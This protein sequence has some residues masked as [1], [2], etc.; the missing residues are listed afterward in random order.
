MSKIYE[1][2]IKDFSGGI[3]D[4][5]R[6]QISNGA[7]LIKHFDIFSDKTR[8]IPHR[9]TEADTNDGSTADGM[10]TYDVRHFTLGS[11]GKL[12][13][14]GKNGSGYPKVVSKADP[15]TGNWTLEATA[16]GNA[17]RVVGAFIEWQG[18]WWFWQGTNQLAKWT[19]GSTVTNSVLTVGSTITTVAQGIIGADNNL[20]MFYNGKVVRINSSGTATDDVLSALPSD[21]RIT[22]V[23]PYGSYIAI[24]IAFGTSATASP[25]GRSK[26]FL[27]DMV[28][29]SSVSDV[30]DW[31]EGALMCLG[32][33]EG[34][35]C[36]VSDKYLSSS[37]G[38]GTG[39]MVVRLWAGGIPQVMKEIVANQT[40]TLGRFLN[41]VV[42]KNNKMYWVA[43]VPF[44]LSTATESTF[45]LGIW[46]FGRKNVNSDFALSLDYIE[47]GID[48]SNYKIVS[49]GAAGD[50]WF[51]NH[52]NDG[53]ITKTDD[54]ANYTFTSIYESQIF[55]NNDSSE[56]K[57]LIGV[58]VFTHPLPAAGQ[59]VLKYKKDEDT[60]WT[61][62]FTYGTDNCIS[63]SAINIE[64]NGNNLPTYKEI[65]F[66]I[67]STGKAEVTGFK[68]KYEIIDSDLY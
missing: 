62:I 68:F 61:T 23:A 30:I 26:V 58:T 13:G 66:R 10:K 25:T 5:L 64:S 1:V 17:A 14:L 67:E 45:H 36:G 21:M 46:V 19:I 33:I 39:S 12:Y 63:H 42:I 59:V 29:T 3:I 27:W 20:Y 11:N 15:T 43:S 49:F 18:A 9:S 2:K 8:L 60:S 48:T 54:A 35:I 40:V 34:R 31:G 22:S 37:L 38:L 65:Q 52:S 51:V 47:E 4:S 44:G 16:E 50:Y 7:S 28:T 55:N 6:E 57:K 32:N 56:T 53:S 41:E 24:G